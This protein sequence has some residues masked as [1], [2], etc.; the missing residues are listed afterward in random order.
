MLRVAVLR[1]GKRLRRAHLHQR[2]PVQ[3]HHAQHN[4]LDVHEPSDIDG[5]DEAP[6]D[7]DGKAGE[8]HDLVQEVDPVIVKHA[9][10][11]KV[12]LLH[13]VRLA[14]HHKLH[15]DHHPEQHVD[16]GRHE[17]QDPVQPERVA[18]ARRRGYP[19]VADVRVHLEPERR[20]REE[21]VHHDIHGHQPVAHEQVR[22]RP[23]DRL[24]P[25][26]RHVHHVHAVHALQ[27]VDDDGALR[28]EP[29]LAV[30]HHRHGRHEDDHVRRES[31]QRRED[32]RLL[33]ELALVRVVDRVERAD[34][35]HQR[36][37]G[38]DDARDPAHGLE[39]V[40]WCAHGLLLVAAGGWGVGSGRC[41]LG[42]AT[43]WLTPTK[44]MGSALE[45]ERERMYIFFARM[46]M[47]V[48]LF[49]SPVSYSIS[50]SYFLI[51]STAS[52]TPS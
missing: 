51:V 25:Q 47:C 23:V 36:R 24:E 31:E 18:H 12:A 50:S 13:R 17:V 26:R 40:W 41:G 3:H 29:P 15:V 38:D 8:R 6:N 52:A 9:E 27:R 19:V 48:F 49:F 7:V 4:L 35:G 39:G 2:K 14:E 43:S 33:E 22:P 37:A 42:E 28:E 20:R 30:D 10:P 45:R 32:T 34:V 11:R 21:R 16:A 5:I 46:L 1:S 44:R